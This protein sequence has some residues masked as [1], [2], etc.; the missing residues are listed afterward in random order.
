[1]INLD[2]LLT[3]GSKAERLLYHCVQRDYGQEWL[4]THF[5]SQLVL[6]HAKTR[7]TP[8]YRYDF[9][10]HYPS[11]DLKQ[12]VKV[13]VEVQGG[14][15]GTH[16][17]KK[18]GHNTGKGIMRDMAKVNFAQCNDYEIFLVHGHATDSEMCEFIRMVLGVVA[19]KRG[20]TLTRLI[21]DTRRP[22][23]FKGT[24]EL[25]VLQGELWG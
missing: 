3:K 14:I 22:E 4:P 17:S 9:Q 18:S 21:P 16:K 20:K 8:R 13:A 25:A 19:S 15:W 12:D 5:D 1:M 10:W 24:E 7:H 23:P 11:L 6:K 2:R